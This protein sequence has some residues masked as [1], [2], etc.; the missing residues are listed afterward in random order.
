MEDSKILKLVDRFKFIY[1]KLGINYPAMRTILKLK[2]LMDNRRVPTIYNDRENND[3][4]NAFKKSL[5]LYGLMGLFLM[6]LIFIPSPMVVKMS[7]NI[8]AIMFLIMSTMI[9]DFSS[10]LLDIRDKNILNTKPLDS[11]TINAAKTTHILIYIT[12]IAGGA[13]AGPT[14]IGGLIKYKFEFF[15][16]FF[17]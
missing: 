2:L 14:L 9:S 16:I 12:S 7:I 4:K 13:I 17:F 3:K 6:A 1:D 15:I 8:G 10:V 11:K 5:F